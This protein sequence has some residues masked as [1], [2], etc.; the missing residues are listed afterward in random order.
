MTIEQKLDVLGR[1]L[2]KRVWT[3]ALLWACIGA[4]ALTSMAFIGAIVWLARP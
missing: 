1:T 4:G 3:P 2:A